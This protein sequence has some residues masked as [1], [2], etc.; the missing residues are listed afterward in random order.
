[1][2]QDQSNKSTLGAILHVLILFFPYIIEET[3]AMIR[4]VGGHIGHTSLIYL[5]V[6]LMVGCL[7]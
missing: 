1:M 5:A 3:E 6:F 4:S 2:T 7:K